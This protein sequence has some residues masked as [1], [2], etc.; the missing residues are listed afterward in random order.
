[1]LRSVAAALLLAAPLAASAQAASAQNITAGEAFQKIQQR[2]GGPIS[3]TTV[4]TLKAGDPATPVTGIA[5]TFL[6][7]MEVLREAAKRG[8]NLVITHEPTFYN[9]PDDTSF[10]QGDPV[11]EEKLAFIREHHMVVYRL[12]DEIH[13]TKPDPIA[14]GLLKALGWENDY[15]D[16]DPFFLTISPTTLGDLVSMLRT[17]LHIAVLPVIG[18]PNLKIS[19][20]AIRPGAS[21]LQKQVLALR[22]DDVDVLIAGEA[23]QWETVEYARDAVA[24]G[25][26]KALIL[27]GHEV[28]EEPG[29]EECAQ[30][31]RA[32]FPGVRIDH[33]VAGQPWWNAEHPPAK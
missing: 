15:K 12:H 22:R 27:I 5:T 18:D 8:D 16:N 10:F 3:G 11:Y 33:I 24:Q 2:Y 19:H 31:L 9:H 20:V 28:S 25:R 7:T 13:A 29:M 23:S 4:D 14:I 32:V 17:R 21:G 26:H 1:M 6:D 30:E